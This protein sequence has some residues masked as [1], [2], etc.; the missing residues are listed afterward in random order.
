MTTFCFGAHGWYVLKE[1]ND[2]WTDDEPSDDDSSDDDRFVIRGGD[3]ESLSEHD[4]L[5]WAFFFQSCNI[6]YNYFYV[7]NKCSK[8]CVSVVCIN[9]YINFSRMRVGPRKSS[10]GQN[11]LLR[12]CARQMM[13]LPN[14]AK[15]KLLPVFFYSLIM[16]DVQYLRYNVRQKC[17]TSIFT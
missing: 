5:I 12:I 7:L 10:I 14:I 16:N 6:L 1:R 15:N 17:C 4:R 3:S 11:I 13:A 9:E 8:S 2:H